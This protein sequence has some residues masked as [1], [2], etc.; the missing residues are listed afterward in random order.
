M[1]RFRLGE[2]AALTPDEEA[3]LWIYEGKGGCWKCHN[4]PNFSDEDFHNTGVGAVDGVPARGRFEITGD[5]ADRGRFRTPG[6]RMLTKT[7]PYMHDGSI[8]TLAEVVEFYRRGGNVN[9][10]RSDRMRELRLT[11]TEARQL[12]A[13]LE[14]LS[15]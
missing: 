12:V 14:A 15:R 3:G 9:S 7:A 8:E 2:R 4:G 10:N 1:D 5:E 11:D 6:L 13:F